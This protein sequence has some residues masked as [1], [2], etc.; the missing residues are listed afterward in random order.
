MKQEDTKKAILSKWF[1]LPETERRTGKQVIAFTL[2]LMKDHPD[3]TNFKCSG[4][5]YQV[6]NG[7][8]SPCLSK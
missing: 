3:I 5:H 6:I 2:K 4:S 1:K 7:F 8:L